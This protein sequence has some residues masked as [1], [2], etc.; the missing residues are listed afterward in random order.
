[1]GHS[2][3]SLSLSWYGLSWCRGAARI[4]YDDQKLE[5]RIASGKRE[6]RMIWKIG[7]AILE[8]VEEFKYL[9]CV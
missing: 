7:K 9:G 4:C 1:M 2:V 8:E 3:S 5:A 6:G